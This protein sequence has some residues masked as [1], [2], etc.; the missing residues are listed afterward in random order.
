M[1]Q[2][3]ILRLEAMQRRIVCGNNHGLVQLQK[4]NS[5]AALVSLLQSLNLLKQT[6]STVDAQLCQKRPSL[7]RVEP[8]TNT[9]AAKLGRDMASHN[10]LPFQ[11]FDQVFAFAT[12]NCHRDG[13][14]AAVLYNMAVVHHS[15]ALDLLE[16][17]KSPRLSLLK[18][19]QLYSYALNAMQQWTRHD[20]E[21]DCHLLRLAI[22]NN[23]AHAHACQD[24]KLQE[25]HHCLQCL[26][27]ILTYAKG[28]ATQE[29]YSFFAANVV[30]LCFQKP[31]RLGLSPAAAA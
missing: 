22:L 8:V 26:C 20:S 4:G 28:H 5:R 6:T 2:Q 9:D 23:L 15:R 30:V 11:M 27:D 31:G 24:N 10:S 29:Q 13:A 14:L 16:M 19:V 3:G 21:E 12:T 17:C 25:A 7:F 18:A 1:D